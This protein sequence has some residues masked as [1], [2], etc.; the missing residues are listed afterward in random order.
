MGYDI[1]QLPAGCPV[2][3]ALNLIGGKWKGMIL[4]HLLKEECLRFGELQHRVPSASL[5]MLT[6]QLREMEADGLISRTVYAEV[7]PKVEYRLTSLGQSTRQII[8]LLATWG[9]DNY[10]F[11]PA[12]AKG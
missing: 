6:K 8:D 4:Y 3:G 5:R 11:G 10:R 12:P 1:D 2:Q 7:P 9:R